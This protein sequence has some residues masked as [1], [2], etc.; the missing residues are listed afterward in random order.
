MVTTKESVPLEFNHEIMNFD[1]G[2]GDISE[3]SNLSYKDFERLFVVCIELELDDATLQE[4][5]K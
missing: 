5:K 3:I 4:R 2:Q 1:Y